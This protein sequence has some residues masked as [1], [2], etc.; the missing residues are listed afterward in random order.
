LERVRFQTG[1]GERKERRDHLEDHGGMC[2]YVLAL[3][4]ACANIGGLEVI[5]AMGVMQGVVPGGKKLGSTR[6][7]ERKRRI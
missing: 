3:L 2:G 4:L 7:I 1:K 6:L 5:G